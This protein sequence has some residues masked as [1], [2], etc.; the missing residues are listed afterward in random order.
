MVMGERGRRG[1]RGMEREREREKG[2]RDTTATLSAFCEPNIKLCH[3][4][5]AVRVFVL[6]HDGAVHV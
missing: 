5:V 2:W 6:R 3:P 4:P 1:R